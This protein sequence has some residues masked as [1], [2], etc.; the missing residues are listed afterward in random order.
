[1]KQFTDFYSTPLK[2]HKFFHYV[3]TPVLFAGSLLVIPGQLTAVSYNPYTAARLAYGILNCCLIAA[4]F[5][6][7]FRWKLYSWYCLFVQMAAEILFAAGTYILYVAVVPHNSFTSGM[8]FGNIIGAAVRST[9]IGIYYYK[10][11]PLFSEKGFN[12]RNADTHSRKSAAENTA[13]GVQCAEDKGTFCTACGTRNTS[14]NLF[15]TAC[16]QALPQRYSAP[17]DVITAE[18][19]YTHQP[20][21]ESKTDIPARTAQSDYKTEQPQDDFSDNIKKAAPKSRR[22]LIIPVTAAVLV[23]ALSALNIFQYSQLRSYK[24]Q[25]DSL[26]AQLDTIAGTIEGYNQRISSLN[27][28]IDD[29]ALSAGYYDIIAEFVSEKLPRYNSSTYYPSEYIL[30]I[31]QNS[32]GESFKLFA[33][34]NSVTV[35]FYTTGDSVTVDYAEDWSGNSIDIMLAP[36]RKGLTR[37]HFSNDMNSDTFQVLVFVV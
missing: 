13:A 33:N 6:G 3:W 12:P 14:H 17:T 26:S 1:M 15:C 19:A 9:L 11:K 36:R 23:A 18:T 29:Y 34:L 20:V 37:I 32:A 2:F 7:F 4:Y 35:S 10:R 21:Q 25:A 5:I 31:P 22:K 16:G 30:F 28:I 27:N 24:A 8:G